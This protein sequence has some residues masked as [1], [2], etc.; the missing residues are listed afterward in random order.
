MKIV[1]CAS[2]DVTPQIQAARMALEKSG[3]SVEI[4]RY[5]QKILAGEIS[6]EDFLARKEEEGDAAFRA[7]A[8]EDLIKRYYNLIKA[9]DA[10]LVL[11]ADKK[12]IKNYIGGNTFLEI[13]FAYILEKKIYLLNPIPEVSYRDEIVAMK[14]VVLNGDLSKIS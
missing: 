4:P 6:L 7:A 13:G 12:G 3:H 11:N 2:V 9:A 10:I 8:G 5:S 14:P 1:I